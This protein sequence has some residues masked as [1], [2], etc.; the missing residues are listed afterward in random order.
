MTLADWA[1]LYADR[2]R[3]AVFP[4]QPRGKVPAT[5]HGCKDASADPGMVREMWEGRPGCNIGLATG[6][7][8]GVFVF[9]VDGKAPPPEK[10]GGPEG[11]AG[12]EALAWL[13]ARWGALPPTRRAM[14]SGGGWHLYFRWPAGRVIKNRARIRV[15]DGRRAGLD[16]R[17]DGGY[18]VLPPSVHPSGELYRWA[19]GTRDIAEAPG[20]LLDLLDPPKSERVAGSVVG[21][22]DVSDRY[23]A[24]V[25]CRAAAP[26]PSSDP[27]FP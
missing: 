13:E 19:D 20:W 6:P 16:V 21:P 2:H 8:S 3:W 14:T 1:E 5:E 18:V 22:V 7:A 15:Q 23:V 26:S 11:V 24:A 25:L 9:D 12:P 10:E 27:K 17:G 4:L